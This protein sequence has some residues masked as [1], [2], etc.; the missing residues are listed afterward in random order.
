DDW[1]ALLRRLSRARGLVEG[2][3]EL[4]RAIVGWHVEGPFLSPEPGYCGAHD[5]A[6]MCDPSPARME[7]LREA[8]GADPVLLTLAP[9]R[10]GAVEAI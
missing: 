2:D 10:A 6:K 1:T 7:E 5:P 9:E 8:A 4:R 3:P